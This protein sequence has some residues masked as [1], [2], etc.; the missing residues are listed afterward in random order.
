MS[1]DY[2][3]EE[4]LDAIFNFFSPDRIPE[5]KDVEVMQK[6]DSEKVSSLLSAISEA[7]DGSPEGIAYCAQVQKSFLRFTM[8]AKSYITSLPDGDPKRDLLEQISGMKDAE[9]DAVPQRATN[10]SAGA[11]S[12][13]VPRDTTK[14]KARSVPDPETVREVEV[15]EPDSDAETNDR[16]RHDEPRR[17]EPQ[18]K[19]RD[20]RPSQEERPPNRHGNQRGGGRGERDDRRDDDRGDRG[21]TE[22]WIDRSPPSPPARVRGFDPN[23]N[24]VTPAMQGP[25][26]Q[27]R[28]WPGLFRAICSAYEQTRSPDPHVQETGRMRLTRAEEYQRAYR[29]AEHGPQNMPT[30]TLMN[31]LFKDLREGLDKS[32][33]VEFK[34]RYV[35]PLSLI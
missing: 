14:K 2:T 24:P 26:F 28:A 15:V 30:A 11:V 19:T 17:E 12:V 1:D 33:P 22:I 27:D 9:A 5:D 35:A 6:C 13:E 4:Y 29:Y 3:D 7:H 8:D 21:Y 20:E 18:R 25:A 10:I 16:E 23:G 31:Q 34:R 32:D